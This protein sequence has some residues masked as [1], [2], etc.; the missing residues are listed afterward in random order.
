[1]LNTLN[2]KFISVS[3]ISERTGFAPGDIIIELQRKGIAAKHLGDNDYLTAEMLLVLFSQDNTDV[4]VT[5]QPICATDIDNRPF[6][7]LSLPQFE[8]REVFRVANATISFV[9]KE[10]RKKPYMVQRRVYFADGSYK[11]VSKCFATREEAEEYAAKVDGERN[12]A[13]FRTEAV[14]IEPTENGREA[15]G[16]SANYSTILGTGIEGAQ[17]VGGNMSFYDYMLY[18]INESEQCNCGYDTKRC[19]ITAAKQIQRQLKALGCDSI[20]LNEIDDTVLNKVTSGLIQ[21][22]L[23]QSSLNKVYIVI[24]MVLKYANCKGYTHVYTD[25]IR[26]GKSIVEEQKRPP[27]SDKELELIFVAAKSNIRLYAFLSIALYTG[28]RPSEI[29]AL[30][31]CDIDF[32][33][34]EVR[35][36]KAIKREKNNGQVAY[37]NGRKPMSVE[38]V[39]KTKSDKGVRPI[40][41]SVEAA[42]ILTVWKEESRG[43]EEDF[44]FSNRNGNALTDSGIHDMWYRFLKKNGLDHH[45]FMIYRYRH[46]FC[47]HLLKKHLP[48]KVQLLMGDSSTSVIMK[49]YN[50][51][52]SED[53]MEEMRGEIDA[54]FHIE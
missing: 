31:W 22:R 23:S 24:T 1:M 16:L 39:G 4:F 30:K 18:Y 36:T 3:E 37:A 15:F 19:Y 2:S 46:T 12:Q 53:V 29:R 43:T 48:Q 47:T 38:Y 21:S 49:N 27:Y 28:M 51:L 25:L 7:E 10:G 26:K 14:H 41:L 40:P 52:C 50:G 34:N 5:N 54:M 20:R 9:S 42:K 32:V 33:K 6:A 17:A 13:G 45:G 8:G 11:R 44:L 35:V